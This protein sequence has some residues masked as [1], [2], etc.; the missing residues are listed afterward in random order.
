MLRKLFVFAL[1]SGL[2]KKAYDV[3]KERQAGYAAEDAPV[4]HTAKRRTRTAEPVTAKPNT[5]RRRSAAR[6]SV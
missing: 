3:Y 5:S 1:T 2:L 6:A 4:R